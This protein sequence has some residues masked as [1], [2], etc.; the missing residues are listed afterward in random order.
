MY[1]FACPPSRRIR[2]I[3]WRSKRPRFL[4]D[5][6]GLGR[7]NYRQE[8]NLAVSIPRSIADLLDDLPRN[9]ADRFLFMISLINSRRIRFVGVLLLI[10]FSIQLI[11]DLTHFLPQGREFYLYYDLIAVAVLATTLQVR[12]LLK[13]RRIERLLLSFLV[14]F[15]LVWGALLSAVQDSPVTFF[16]ILFAAASLYYQRWYLSLGMFLLAGGVYLGTLISLS[17]LRINSVLLLELAGGVVWAWVVNRILY[18]ARLREFESRRKVVAL[19][20]MQQGMIDTKT[21]ELRQKVEEREILLHEL[22]HRVKNNLQILVSLLNLELHGSAERSV[23]EVVRDSVNRVRSMYTIHEMLYSAEDLRAVDLGAYLSRLSEGILR[24]FQPDLTVRLKRE[25]DEC[26]VDA[27]TTLNLGLILNEAL[28]NAMQH[29]FSDGSHEREIRL[30]LAAPEL[31]RRLL[32]TLADNG[33]GIRPED[34]EGSDSL[35]LRLIRSLAEQMGGEA[36]IESPLYNERGTRVS[37]S[38]PLT[39]K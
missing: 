15:L 33:G 25:M 29:A 11:I 34:Q 27:D 3:A 21:E 39:K 37:I 38:I 4:F 8:L 23:E 26:K 9:E 19:S 22:H 14:L 7:Y 12:I 36:S 10:F 18:R 32:L 13:R 24:S 35:G 28:T 1:R 20:R 6:G 16:L 2:F 30:S 17:P 5:Y 31:S